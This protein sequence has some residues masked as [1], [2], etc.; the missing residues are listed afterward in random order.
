MPPRR[1]SVDDDFLP[2]AKIL[3][4]FDMIA[5]LRSKPSTISQLATIYD[6]SERTIYRYIKLL[7]E[8]NLC[9]DVNKNGKYFIASYDDSPVQEVFSKEESNVLKSLVQAGAGRNALRDSLLKKL[10]LFSSSTQAVALYQKARLANWVELFSQAIR[11]KKQVILENYHSANS[12]KVANRLIEPYSLGSNYETIHALD[13]ADKKCKFFKLE[14]IGKVTLLGQGWKHETQHKNEA[15]DIFGM[16]TGKETWVT[17]Q[18]SLRAYLLLVEEYPKAIPF[19]I[20]EQGE[21]DTKYILTAPVQGLNGISRFALGLCDEITIISPKALK[22]EMDE[23]MKQFA[24]KNKS[25]K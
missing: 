2:Q 20:H 8:L 7:E 10:S 14:R 18:L 24:I 6:M 9:L 3:R 25:K 23:K 22:N 21:A 4:V 19:V 16:V 17:L 5:R 13:V 15:E 1:D 11:E 12:Q